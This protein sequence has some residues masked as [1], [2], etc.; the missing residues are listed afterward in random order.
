MKLRHQTWGVLRREHK[1]G[2]GK[3]SGW[4]NVKKPPQKGEDQDQDFN[5]QEK[6]RRGEFSCHFEQ[7]PGRAMLGLP[8]VLEFVGVMDFM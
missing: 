4:E 7:R 2:W 3:Q 8:F 5:L 1:V 6:D